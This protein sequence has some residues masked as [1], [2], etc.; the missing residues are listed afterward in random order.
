MSV[1]VARRLIFDNRMSIGGELGVLKERSLI[2]TRVIHVWL[3]LRFFAHAPQ[4]AYYMELGANP[5]KL[6]PVD[7]L[8]DWELGVGKNM[9]A[10][11]VR[12]LHSIAMA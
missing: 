5:A 12:I 8:H 1:E 3:S 11:N 4:N 10:H 7:P 6:M 9:F 2:P